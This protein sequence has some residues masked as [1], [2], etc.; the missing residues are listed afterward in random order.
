LEQEDPKVQ[1]AAKDIKRLLEVD[2]PPSPRQLA[3][4]HLARALLISRVLSLLPNL[5]PETQKEIADATGV[6]LDRAKAQTEM[7]KSEDRGFD[8][9]RR[10]P[11]LHLVKGRRLLMEDQTDAAIAE[12]RIAIKL[13]PSRAQSHIEL[14]RALMRKP[15]GEKEAAEA[16]STAL[17][18]VGESPR[19]MYM[20]GNAYRRQGRLDD[21]IAQYLKALRD[22][23]ARNP[24]ARLALGSSYMQKR[25][26]PKAREVLE[27]AAQEFIGQAPKL[28]AAYTELG[29]L[30]EQQSDRAKADEA[31]QK[32]L[33]TDADFTPAYFFYARFLS[34]DPS[35]GSKA[36]TLGQEYLKRDPNGEYASE[37]KRLL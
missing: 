17:R 23:K 27:K 20:L 36:R 31:Y 7:L 2:P 22:P 14:A 33:N 32:A 3:G 11:E 4:A 26:F 8:L 5:K 13:D 34:S 35:Q 18:T 16:L 25:D 10:D 29:R 21:A 1:F 19:L 12:T 30:Y 9:D 24:D 15:G 6:P 37:A 28:A